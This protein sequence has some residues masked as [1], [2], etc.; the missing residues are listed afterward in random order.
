MFVSF[1]NAQI[2]ENVFLVQFNVIIFKEDK[3][4]EETNGHSE[5]EAS[6]HKN[7]E[8]SEKELGEEGIEIK[9]LE[10]EPETNRNN[11]EKANLIN[12]KVK[13][14]T[15][16]LDFKEQLLKDY[17]YLISQGVLLGDC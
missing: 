7:D 17:S 4:V 2:F 5:A 11:D 12:S 15:N 6:K 16:V 13:S 1:W 10:T 14:V 3:K 8:E 9:K